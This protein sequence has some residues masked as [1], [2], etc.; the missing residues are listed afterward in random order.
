MDS[1]YETYRVE[2]Y[3]GDEMTIHDDLL[4]HHVALELMRDIWRQG[5]L[6]GPRY[7]RVCTRGER[8]GCVRDEI[9]R[10]AEAAE[11]SE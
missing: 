11:R 10:G 7:D 1:D 9:T 8:T 6:K 2:S 5:N 3:I 4:L